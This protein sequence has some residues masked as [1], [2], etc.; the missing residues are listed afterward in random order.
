MRP[1]TVV[2]P[3]RPWFG[4][5]WLERD[6]AVNSL[7]VGLRVYVLGLSVV[8]VVVAGWLLWQTP[9]SGPDAALG[10]VLLG[11]GALSV[12]ATRRLGEPAG[13]VVKDLLSAWWLPMAVL[14]PPVFVLLAPLPL[15][16]LTQWRVRPTLLH[17]RLFSAASIGLSY[18]AASLA[19]HALAPHSALP[20]G[21]G[22]PPGPGLLW[23][24]VAV[25]AAGLLAAALNTALIAVAVKAAD[26]QT[27]WRELLVDVQ[28]LRLD[29]VEASLGVTVAV[30]VGL[31]PVLVVFTLAPILVLQR[32][33]LHGQLR[34]VALLDPKTGLLNAVT[35]EREAEGKLLALR[36]K[37][38]PA[39]V[40]LIDVDHFKS[41][42]DTYGHLAG[43]LVLRE[44]SGALAG[45]VRDGDLVGRFGGEEFVAL[46]PA[47]DAGETAFVAERL[48]ALVA[49]LVV[50]L[51][52]GVAARTTVSIGVAT[53]P[54]SALSVPE[55]LAAADHCMYQAKA[56]GRNQVVPCGG[57]RQPEPGVTRS[58]RFVDS[59]P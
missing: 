12:E 57:N 4:R 9:P 28:N 3:R 53:S 1:A 39:A 58:V 6:W 27:R 22:P 10:A 19:F 33:L 59:G 38:L 15:M 16:A 51:Q 45:G 55:M 44:I 14:L 49:G 17:R 40:L 20:V 50:T 8:V 24:A 21:S 43:D 46:L 52:D 56:A 34:A 13:T 11:L 36:R 5:G 37:G 25:A 30:L 35:W 23:W 7:P 29:A 41:V 26:A 32:G 47:A 18:A 42:N 54:D 31:E 48:R 2:V